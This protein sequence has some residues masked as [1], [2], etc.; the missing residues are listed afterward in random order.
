MRPLPSLPYE[1][2]SWVYGRSVNLDFHVVYN[3]N[4]YSCPYQYSGKRVDLRLTDTLLKIY[5]KGER[6][7]THNRFPD[8]MKN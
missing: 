2:S 5:Y 3:K 6:V 1:I 4:R 8:Y 7:T